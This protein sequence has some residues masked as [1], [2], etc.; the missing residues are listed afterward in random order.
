MTMTKTDFNKAKKYLK[1]KL[2]H[3]RFKFDEKLSVP[4]LHN[5]EGAEDYICICVIE[6]FDIV[7]DLSSKKD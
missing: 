6:L 2:P 7:N 5:P 1:S 3:Y 4:Y